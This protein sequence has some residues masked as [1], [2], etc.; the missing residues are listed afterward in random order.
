MRS[1]LINCPSSLPI[2]L[3]LRTLRELDRSRQSP[4]SIGSL[5]KL[6]LSLAGTGGN[7]ASHS[8]RIVR[9]LVH[10]RCGLGNETSAD[11]FGQSRLIHLPSYAGVDLYVILDKVFAFLRGPSLN[12]DMRITVSSSKPIFFRSSGKQD[13]TACVR[14]YPATALAPPPRITPAPASE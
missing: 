6:K 5:S 4:P 9:R 2:D 7:Q 3:Q 14:V 1:C 11:P 13:Q 12:G 10:G 8:R